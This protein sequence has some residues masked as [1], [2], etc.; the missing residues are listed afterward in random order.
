MS[1]ALVIGML[2]LLC[3]SALGVAYKSRVHKKK[4]ELYIRDVEMSDDDA[5]RSMGKP[6]TIVHSM[7]PD[8]LT[9]SKPKSYTPVKVTPITPSQYRA[10]AT[11]W[12]V[13]TCSWYGPGLYGNHTANGEV[14][15]KGMTNFAH[16]S[17]PFGTK[18][19][20]QYKGRRVIARC[21]DRGP[22][23]AG[24]TFDLGPG[25]AQA[26]GFQGVGKV[27]WRYLN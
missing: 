8:Y 16:R 24:R 19:E 18:V 27:Q 12:N 4:P 20:F 17:M 15:V 26:L 3:L 21:N 23:V 1:K 11:G 9:K 6:R 5:I 7:P 2:L 14:L 13:A 25:T 22:F 10:R